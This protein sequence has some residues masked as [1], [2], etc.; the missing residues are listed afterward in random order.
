M[1]DDQKATDQKATI[2]QFNR[3]IR[4]EHSRHRVQVTSSTSRDELNRE[5]RRA[6]GRGPQHAEAEPEPGTFPWRS[7]QTQAK[8]RGA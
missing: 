7:L 5:L 1:T 6:A 8:E 4:D 2:S 3:Q